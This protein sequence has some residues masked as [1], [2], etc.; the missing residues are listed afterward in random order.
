[1]LQRLL[2]MERKNKVTLVIQRG[3]NKKMEFATFDLTTEQT[4]SLTV[5]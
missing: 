4:G 1:M 2:G 5:I 3:S